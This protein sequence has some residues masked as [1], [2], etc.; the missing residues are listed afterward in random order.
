MRIDHPVDT[1]ALR[2]LWKQAFGDSDAFLDLFFSTAFAPD[3][4]LC[5]TQNGEPAAALYWLDCEADG[6]KIAYIY[7]VATGIKFRRQGICHKLMEK[8]HEILEIQG[9]SGTILV[10]GEPALEAFYAPMGYRCRTR[11]REVYCARGPEP[12]PL[13]PIDAAEYA[14][15]RREMLP[16]GAVLQEGAALSFLAGQAEFYAGTHLLLAARREGETLFGLELLGDPAAAPGILTTLGCG[17]GQFRTPGEGRLF[18][19]Y[20]PLDNSPA[21]TYFAFAF[22]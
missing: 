20:R 19:M 15:L 9:Y 8:A 12:I 7:A 11:L 6:R 21:P 1:A 16:P 13:R 18:A 22:D 4:C 17:S 5:A 10:P 14:R 3:H 2:A